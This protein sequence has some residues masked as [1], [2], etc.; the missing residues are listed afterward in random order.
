MK[1]ILTYAILLFFTLGVGAQ[2]ALV[3]NNDPYIVFNGGTVGTPIYLVVNQ[4]NA[5]GIV[6]QGTGGNIISEDEYNYVKWNIGTSS[7][8][9]TIPFTTGIGGTEQKIPL[10]VSTTTAGTGA[11]DLLFSTYESDDGNLPWPSGVTHFMSSTGNLDNKDWVV[12]RFWIIDAENYAT[13]PAVQLNFGFNDDA[14]EVGAPNTLNP[15]NLGAQRFNPTN[16]RWEGSHSGSNGIW[17]NVAGPVASPPTA[18]NNRV[19]NI[20]IAASEFY[21]A[22]T[23]TDYDHPLPLSLNY[24]EGSCDNSTVSL[25]WEV[26]TSEITVYEVQKS[27]DGINFTTI[28]TTSSINNET[29]F[30]YIDRNPYIKQSYYR[31]MG[32]GIESDFYSETTS[33]RA[34]DNTSNTYI[35]SPLSNS[36]IYVELTSKTEY[37]YNQFLLVDLSGKIVRQETLTATNKGNNQFI[38]DA[39]GIA[40]GIY[41]AV[42]ISEDGEKTVT[43][44]I[45]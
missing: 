3:L 34:C 12:D 39:N 38:I 14:T 44:I 43:K 30:K 6:T 25:D 15:A 13:K 42:L 2:N 23:L 32:S 19:E 29:S 21:R 16:N 36:N 40:T 37:S 31:I 33:V 22:W 11:G 20:Q 41:S 26:S 1:K 8:S 35:F 45:L 27:L 28:G 18:G 9:F 17:G 4:T 5:N 10:T 7:G 24:F